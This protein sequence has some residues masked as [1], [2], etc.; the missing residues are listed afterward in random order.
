M[1][2][3]AFIRAGS[4]GFLGVTL[5]DYL[6]AEDALAATGASKD[7]KTRA[8]SII[9][10]WLDGGPS[11][12]D[13]W[14]PK[15]GSAFKAIGTNVP[16]IQISEL[17]PRIAR[18]M[19]K[20][21][22][23]RSMHT[24]ENNHGVAHH[25]A[26]TGH[27]PTAAM[28]FPSLGA[29]VTKELGG[30]NNVPPHILAPGWKGGR[31]FLNGAFL[32][33]EYNPMSVSDPNQEGFRVEDLSLPKTLSLERM[34][35]RRSL[36]DVV[37]RYY[38][39]KVETAEHRN[40]D[41]FSQQALDIVTS[42]G[43]RAAFD[44]AGEPDKLRDAYGRHSFGQTLLLARRLVEAGGRF[45]T[46]AGY[47][48]KG[49]DTHSDNDKRVAQL[50]PPFDQSLPVL[51]DDLAQHGLLDSTIVLV[52]G[53]FG[54][55]PL[56]NSKGGRDHWPACWS[57]ALGGGGLRGGQIVG[58]SDERG[59]YVAERMVTIGDLYATLYKALGIDWHKEYPSPIGRPIKIANSIGDKTGEVIQELIG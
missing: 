5:A 56:V 38:R 39:S 32:G 8:Q 28:Q 33:A 31:D 51:L 1:G 17:L 6:R 4:L 24:E 16:G 29:I 54:R 10:V 18:C 20:L 53:E 11:H 21:S 27:R 46:V 13:T 35:G 30:R 55:T 26:F 41:R 45:V 37:D 49:W 34:E 25:Y 44:L 43:V 14:D 52:M 9:M 36:R 19:D 57:L 59:A 3:R 7:P 48:S 42:P 58:R 40:M 50:A 47:D 22:I 23:V 2:R 12:V 15:P